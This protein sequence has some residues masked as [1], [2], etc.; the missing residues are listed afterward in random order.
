LPLADVRFPGAQ[1]MGLRRANVDGH[2]VTPSSLTATE[3][4]ADAP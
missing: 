4:L 3:V 1:I 2:V